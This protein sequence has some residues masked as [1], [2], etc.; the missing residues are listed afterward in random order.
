MD[1]RQRIAAAM[2]VVVAFDI[3]AG[4]VA[5]GLNQRVVAETRRSRDAAVREQWM[6]Q[7]AMRATQFMAESSGLVMDVATME[8]LERS[9]KYG[10]LIGSDFNVARALQKPPSAVAEKDAQEVRSAWR[11]MRMMTLAWVNAES[12]ATGSSLR[13]RLMP[14]ESVRASV[15]SD[16]RLPR[17]LA[18]LSLPEMHE[19]VRRHGE[20][21]RDRLLR[22][23]RVQ[24]AG[25]AHAA[26]LA[27][28]DARALATAATTGLLGSCLVV[29]ILAGLWLYRTIA[30]PLASARL[31]AE[32]VAAGDLDARFE[33]HGDD[34]IGGL[35]H[36]VE[37]MRDAVVGK[38][39]I[40]REMA[41]VV[42]VTSDGVRRAAAVAGDVADKNDARVVDAIAQVNEQSRTLSS[43]AS[44]L[45]EA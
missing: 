7:V 19:A 38:I 15:Y 24:A 34:E 42:I 26:Q 30:R 29:A 3:F 22:G 28:A 5:L 9:V 2:A 43:L 36:A 41:G 40:M 18:G 23:M 6:D 20:V 16:V 31:I 1:V 12:E 13:L 39:A 27:E 33:R 35:I 14:N 44:Q 37:G 10:Q 45:M 25:E 17:S 4:I 32:S 11:D 21:F 8:T